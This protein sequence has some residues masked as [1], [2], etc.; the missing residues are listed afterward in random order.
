[1]SCPIGVG[2]SAVAAAKEN[3]MAADSAVIVDR[4]IFIDSYPL[5]GISF[6]GVEEQISDGLM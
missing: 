5:R 2:S 3:S 1:M 6:W 4:V